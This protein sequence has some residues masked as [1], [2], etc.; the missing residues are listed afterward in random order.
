MT[1]TYDLRYLDEVER[2]IPLT[3]LIN[4]PFQVEEIGNGNMNYVYRIKECNCRKT[5]IL[6]FAAK[7]TRISKDIPVSNERI[8]IEAKVLQQFRNLVSDFVPRIYLYDDLNKCIIMEECNGYT[9]MRNALNQYQIVNNFSDSITTYLVKSI[10]PSLIS[11]KQQDIDV[12]FTNPLCEVTKMFVF[13]EP[14]DPNSSTNAIY[15]PNKDFVQ[16]EILSDIMLLKHV[17]LLKENFTKKKQALLHGDLHTGS[18]FVK[19]SS[20]IVFDYE[21]A[22][23]G[24]IGFDIGNLIA[25][26]IFAWI[27]ARVEHVFENMGFIN[28]IENT[29]SEIIDKFRE[30]F[31]N[32]LNR[33]T[34]TERKDVNINIDEVINDTASFAGVELLRRI[35][36]IAHVSDI[37]LIESEKH[38]IQAERVAMKLAKNYI[39]RCNTFNTGNDFLDALKTNY[40][41]V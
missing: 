28:W 27:H 11:E 20:V 33:L 10:V 25:N 29:I 19:H 2:Y 36:G 17:D 26:L 4:S 41:N 5:F 37:T 1:K 12:S 40:E 30:K 35:I 23:Y 15:E 31:K 34:D 7:H 24:P 39:L 9:V 22:F 13:T 38:R 18:I 21:F 3:G 32:E 8:E 16:S 6:K 14:F